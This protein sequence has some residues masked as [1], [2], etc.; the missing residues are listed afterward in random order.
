MIQDI[1]DESGVARFGDFY[2]SMITLYEF[3]FAR[4]RYCENAAR[5]NRWSGYLHAACYM[6]WDMDRIE[7]LTFNSTL[8]RNEPAE[9][10]VDVGLAHARP[11]VQPSFLHGLGHQRNALPTFVDA[12]FRT[13][14]DRSDLALLILQSA[15]QCETGNIL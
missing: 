5:H 6:L 8:R 4:S 10:L 15:E 14:L 1:L 13:C 12:K 2:E 3:G 7:S 9:S 11:E